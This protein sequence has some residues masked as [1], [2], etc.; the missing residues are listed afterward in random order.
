MSFMRERLLEMDYIFLLRT[1]DKWE[2][3][4]GVVER[5]VPRHF[6]LPLEFCSGL[7]IISK[8]LQEKVLFLCG[9]PVGTAISQV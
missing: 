3:V 6:C 8:Q 2:T 4:L 7:S 9:F 5:G 1:A